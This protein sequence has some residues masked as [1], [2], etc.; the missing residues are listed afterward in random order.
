MESN[1]VIVD[2]KKMKQLRL[3]KDYSLKEMAD[4]LGYKS[5]NGYL[6]LESGRCAIDATQLFLIA[7]KLEVPSMEDLL[8]CPQPTS[9][10][11]N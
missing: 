6:Y 1:K 3:E 9:T 5:P 11:A 2:L 7:Q 10:V 4:Y 8:L